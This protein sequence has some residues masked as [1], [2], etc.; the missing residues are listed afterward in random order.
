MAYRQPV[1]HLTQGDTLPPIRLV[2]YDSAHPASG[3]TI[4]PNDP[5]T[6]SRIDLRRVDHVVLLFKPTQAFQD[7]IEIPCHIE[8]SAHGEISVLWGDTDLM[9]EGSF[10]GKV[11]LYYKE[12]DPET[13]R[14]R[15][16]K[17]TS[18]VEIP[19]EIEP[20]F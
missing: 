1:I 19:F 5:D 16:L 4:N 18:K 14:S 12:I 17:W 20:L 9:F 2:V 13:D 11:R 15:T 6:W 3:K 10:V 8:N 7:P